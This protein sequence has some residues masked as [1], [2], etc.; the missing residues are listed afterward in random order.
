MDKISVEL[1]DVQKTL[2]LPLWGRAFESK[3]EKPLL[4]DRTALE[5]IEKVNYDFAGIAKN[6]S[7]LS[8]VAWI[9]RSIYIDEVIKNFLDQHPKATIVNIGCG[10]DTTFDK[11]ITARFFGTTWI[12]RMSSS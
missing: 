4:R 9:M 8:Q 2:F 6:I 10:M 11:S 5:I 3:K 7:E 12:C 1:G